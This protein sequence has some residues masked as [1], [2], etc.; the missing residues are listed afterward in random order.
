MSNNARH[1][2]MGGEAPTPSDLVE[3]N[4]RLREALRELH[5]IVWGECPSL[6]DG[7]SGGGAGLDLEIEELLSPQ[8]TE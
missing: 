8:G 2:S 3:E 4:R 7:D 5:A 1:R 6:L